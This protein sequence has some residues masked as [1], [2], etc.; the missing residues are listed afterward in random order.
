MI[1]N[2]VM[3]KACEICN[4][5]YLEDSKYCPTCG[6][7]NEEYAYSNQIN[8][9]KNDIKKSDYYKLISAEEISYLGVNPHD[10]DIKEKI[11]PN[12]G[13]KNTS[14]S[15]FCEDCGTKLTDSEETIKANVIN[16]C[17]NCGAIAHDGDKFCAE[18]GEKLEF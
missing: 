16:Y 8:E 6:S 13:C 4:S 12:C 1:E 2:H 5:E 9:I 14:D 11:C 3:S 10:N 18:C 15:Q 17:S 7:K